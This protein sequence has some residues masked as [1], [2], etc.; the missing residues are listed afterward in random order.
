MQ[1]FLIQ[2]KRRVG[3]SA[4]DM[5]F[6]THCCWSIQQG[7][8]VLDDLCWDE[9]LGGTA[10]CLI[11]G[12]DW[13]KSGGWSDESQDAESVVWELR[14]DPVQPGAHRYW[15]SDFSLSIR[16]Y[17]TGPLTADE[18]I[19]FIAAQTLTGCAHQLSHWMKNYEQW[20]RERFSRKEQKIAGLLTYQP[21]TAA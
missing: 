15:C 21:E 2:R 17:F 16:E 4:F 6:G 19:G 11:N 5:A 7:D 1:P 8:N 18:A 12:C 14:V 10:R 3:Y 20:S 13:P 9:M